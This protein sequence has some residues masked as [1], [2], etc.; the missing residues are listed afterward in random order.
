MT[1]KTVGKT[2]NPWLQEIIK[3]LPTKVNQKTIILIGPIFQI[4][5]TP[6][7]RIFLYEIIWIAD[8][9]KLGI[10]TKLLSFLTKKIIVPNQS[11]EARYLRI[12]IKNQKLQLVYPICSFEQG[13]MR[14]NDSLILCCDGSLTI[15]NGMGTLLR[16]FSMAQ[17]ILGNLKLIIGGNILEKTRIEWLTNELGLK[18]DT[19]FAPSG[20]HLW[21]AQSHIYIW[22]DKNDEPT[23]LSLIQAMC[24][25]KAIIASDKLSNHEFIE[26]NKNGI[27]IKSSNADMLSQAIIN[28]AR[29]PDWI[30]ELG[31]NNF[32]F[33]KE[34]FSAE[35]FKQK[36]QKIF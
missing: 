17:E 9:P 28:L 27:L 21:S 14:K 8:N 1:L 31:K 5:I 12:G 16:G 13:P 20:S 7:A 24:F 18:N 34:K 3:N 36:I 2:N 29:K 4:L 33:A 26:Q 6:I 19:Q 30:E 15:E 25:H 23:P 10:I 22:L 35:A 32:E 11:V